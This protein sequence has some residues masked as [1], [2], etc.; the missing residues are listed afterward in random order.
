MSQRKRRRSA[1][2]L[3][4]PL[5]PRVLLSA[6]PGWS[7]VHASTDY[8]IGPGSIAFYAHHADNPA[9]NGLT[10]RFFLSADTQVGNADDVL[11]ASSPYATSADP[12]IAT[13][14]DLAP[15][16]YHFFATCDN[17]HPIS[18]G[19]LTVYPN[20]DSPD[21]AITPDSDFFGLPPLLPRR[22]VPRRQRGRHEPRQGHR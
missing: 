1:S 22:R 20:P 19:D 10:V 11:L 3:F 5:M 8:S 12:V 6:D 21:L 15:G 2:P 9:L 7:N 17:A 16:T 18:A 13:L 4:E 14:P